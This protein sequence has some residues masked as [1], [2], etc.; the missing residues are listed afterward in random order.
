MVSR[1]RWIAWFIRP[2]RITS[3][4]TL[5]GSNT[6]IQYI[7]TSSTIYGIGTLS[8]TNIIRTWITR[9][10]VITRCAD[11]VFKILWYVGIKGICD[12][13][14]SKV[15]DQCVCTSTT[16]QYTVSGQIFN[17]NKDN[18]VTGPSIYSVHNAT[19]GYFDFIITSTSR[20]RYRTVVAFICNNVVRIIR[21]N[22]LQCIR[23]CPAIGR[24]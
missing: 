13:W 24:A 17:I 19:I 11:Q 1:I 5:I 21:P 16:I 23:C 8:S 12:R 14:S 9:Q 20:N 7:V 3:C 2:T 15:K 10:S 4:C 18:V 22:N 6:T